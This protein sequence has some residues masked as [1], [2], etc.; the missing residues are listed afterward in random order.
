[1][2][3]PDTYCLHLACVKADIAQQIVHCSATLQALAE[4]QADP[5]YDEAATDLEKSNI[6]GLITLITNGL[7]A[8]QAI[9]WEEVNN[10]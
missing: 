7:E 9:V 8:L 6:S 10:N 3:R 1:M 5:N 4:I 2:T